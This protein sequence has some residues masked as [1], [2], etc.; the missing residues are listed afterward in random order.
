MSSLPNRRVRILLIV[1]LKTQ[2][3]S[4][5]KFPCFQTTMWE[6]KRTNIECLVHIGLYMHGIQSSKQSYDIE[7]IT[8]IYKRRWWK[9]KKKKLPLIKS[10]MMCKLLSWDSS[11]HTG[12]LH[13]TIG[14]KETLT[15]NLDAFFFFPFPVRDWRP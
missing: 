8:L 12:S 5:T 10:H 6:V 1:S 13:S 2:D 7:N 3:W 4:L 9:Q 15:Y 11:V 14:T